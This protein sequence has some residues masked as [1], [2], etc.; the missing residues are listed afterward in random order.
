MRDL[1]ELYSGRPTPEV[2]G[3]SWHPHAVFED[4]FWK[5]KGI[6]EISAQWYAMPK[7]L[8]KAEITSSRV[9]SSTRHPNRLV[10]AQTIAYTY[11]Y[12]GSTK[13]VSSIVVVDLD[14]EDR[15]IR[16]VDQWDGQAPPTHYG[17]EL[18]RRGHGKLGPWLFHVPKIHKQH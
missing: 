7:F 14:D 18:L 11:R 16:L 9:M 8:S 13:S 5:C 3:R 1:K 6:E 17:A 12:I 2:L 15:I 10:F 4:H